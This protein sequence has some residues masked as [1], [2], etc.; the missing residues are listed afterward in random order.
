MTVYVVV[1]LM[2]ARPGTVLPLMADPPVAF[3]AKA[4]CEAAIAPLAADAVKHN[5]RV[6]C[7]PYRVVGGPQERVL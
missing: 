5:A 1:Y 2:L 6:A 7:R 3:A 4:D